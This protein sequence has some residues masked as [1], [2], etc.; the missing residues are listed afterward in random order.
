MGASESEL[1]LHQREVVIELRA[2]LPLSCGR[3]GEIERQWLDC[4]AIATELGWMPAW[5]LQRGLQATFEW[6][7]SELRRG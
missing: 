4:S 7:A 3:E 1:E 6:Y 5:D 2:T